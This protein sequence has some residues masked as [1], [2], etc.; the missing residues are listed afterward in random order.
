MVYFE[1]GLF[2]SRIASVHDSLLLG[3]IWSLYGVAVGLIYL[4]CYIF[5][6]HW[7]IVSFWWCWLIPC[8]GINA[9]L[10][11]AP[12]GIMNMKSFLS[13]YFPDIW[14][15]SCFAQHLRWYYFI[16]CVTSS[17]LFLV[18]GI[19]SII[20]YLFFWI[21]ILILNNKFVHMLSIG[22]IPPW[23]HWKCGS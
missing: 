3:C 8:G 18:S 6:L 4:L 5:H 2:S 19:L 12:H 14:N 17:L 20:Y 13:C 23:M 7:K 15:M 16:T 10:H 21:I 1:E 9:P 11:L 22:L